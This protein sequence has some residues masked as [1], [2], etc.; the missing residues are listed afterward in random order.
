MLMEVYWTESEGVLQN[1]K[2]ELIQTFSE[3]R[4]RQKTFLRISVLFPTFISFFAITIFAWSFSCDFCIYSYTIWK[5]IC[6]HFIMTH[7]W[8]VNSRTS[9]GVGIYHQILGDFE[10]GFYVVNYYCVSDG[11]LTS[12]GINFLKKNIF[13]KVDFTS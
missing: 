13:N 11:F 10:F 12:I 6:L 3:M 2:Q 4:S 8:A 7:D 5:V 1:I 9:T